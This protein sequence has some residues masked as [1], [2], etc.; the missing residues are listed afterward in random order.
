MFVSGYVSSEVAS[1]WTAAKSLFL[2]PAEWAAK[3]VGAPNLGGWVEGVWTIGIF[4][5]LL[6]S[7]F[8]A[9]LIIF[10]ATSS[11]GEAVRR[12]ALPVAIVI[13]AGQMAKGLAKLTSW[14]GFFP[15]A[16]NTRFRVST[17][18]A[19]AARTFKQPASLPFKWYPSLVWRW[20]WPPRGSPRGNSA[21]PTAQC[22]RSGVFPYSS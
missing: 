21:S 22:A 8:A 11:W 4:P 16:W 3:T 7:L 13:A 1:E 17:S 12:I 18:L 20:S 10:K 6:W 19:M 5:L 15:V 9:L 14:V 2:A